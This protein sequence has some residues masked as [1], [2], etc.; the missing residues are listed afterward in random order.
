MNFIWAL[1]KYFKWY[2]LANFVW[3]CEKSTHLKLQY[4][5]FKKIISVNKT[6]KSASVHLLA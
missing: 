5:Y 6:L 1:F 3:E 2:V 4:L